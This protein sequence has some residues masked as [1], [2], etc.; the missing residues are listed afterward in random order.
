MYLCRTAESPLPLYAS[1]GPRCQNQYGYIS[2]GQVAG[3]LLLNFGKQNSYALLGAGSSDPLSLSLGR[4]LSFRNFLDPPARIISIF[5]MRASLSALDP[6]KNYS[7]KF[8]ARH[9]EGGFKRRH[10]CY[11]EGMVNTDGRHAISF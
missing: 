10:F 3:A 9:A 8:E 4:L 2:M 1:L 7:G 5:V 11:D 6:P